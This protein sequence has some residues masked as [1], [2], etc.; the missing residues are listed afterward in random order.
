MMAFEAM[1]FRAG[2]ASGDPDLAHVVGLGGRG[3]VGQD[4][5]EGAG[6]DL[7]VGVAGETGGWGGGEGDEDGAGDVAGGVGGYPGVVVVDEGGRWGWRIRGERWGGEGGG[8][9]G[10]GV[11]VFALFGRLVP[12]EGEG[13]DHYG[14]GVEVEEV[15]IGS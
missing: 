2:D 3:V 4:V 1:V 7:A 15:E 9:I 11:E 14:G 6:E 8:G 13:L 5:L 10:W 12:F